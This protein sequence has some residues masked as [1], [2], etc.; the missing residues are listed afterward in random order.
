MSG[1]IIR[2]RPKIALAAVTVTISLALLVPGPLGSGPAGAGGPPFQHFRCW[3]ASFDKYDGDR[4][5]VDDDWYTGDGINVRT[6]Q[7]KMLCNPAR[8][9]HGKT[10]YPIQFPDHHLVWYPVRS[11][12]EISDSE[13]ICNNQFVESCT[14]FELDGPVGMLV[15]TKKEGHDAPEGL[16]H[17]L[18]YDASNVESFPDEVAVRDQFKRGPV[19]VKWMKYHCTQV[20]KT[21]GDDFFNAGGDPANFLECFKTVAFEFGENNRPKVNIR[22]QLSAGDRDVVVKRSRLLCA[23]SRRD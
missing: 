19:E 11:G 22:N 6:D 10:I 2:A 15:P 20:D 23:P 14:E 5:L 13:A 12:T 7:P 17:L 3:E 4:L 18:C 9:V 16:W 1:E 21:H 8:K